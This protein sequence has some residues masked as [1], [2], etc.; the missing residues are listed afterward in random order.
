MSLWRRG[1]PEE[2]NGVESLEDADSEEAGGNARARWVSIA[3]V[4]R[5]QGQRG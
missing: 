5:H 1:W 2:I 3:R 4:T